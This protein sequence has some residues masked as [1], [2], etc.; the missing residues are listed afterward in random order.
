[1]SYIQTNPKKI[2]CF[3]GIFCCV[4][5]LCIFFIKEQQNTKITILHFNDLHSH[6]LP[7]NEEGTEC[8]NNENCFG[9]I[10]RMKSAIQ[11]V[12]KDNPEALLLVAGDV[13]QGTVFFTQYK[14]KFLTI[15]LNELD[16][17][18]MGLGNHEFDEGEVVFSSFIK[19]VNFP[20]LTGNMLSAT[21]SLLSPLEKTDYITTIGDKKVGIIS[22][23]TTTT[24]QISSSGEG[25][26]FEDEYS[27]LT[28][29]ATKLHNEGIDIIIAV[30]HV[31]YIKDMA[32]AREV[33]YIDVIV[34]GHSDTLLSNI[35]EK[36]EGKYTTMIQNRSGKKVAVVQTAPYGTQ[37]GKLDIIFNRDGEI[38]SAEGE[39]IILT[40]VMAEDTEL[41]QKIADKMRILSELYTN[42]IG[43]LREDVQG[44]PT[45]CRKTECAMGNLITD[46]FL[47]SYGERYNVTMSVI[48]SGS[49]R[50][51]FNEGD[52]TEAELISVLPFTDTLVVAKITGEQLFQIIETSLSHIEFRSGG[53][54]QIGGFS[55]FFNPD[56]PQNKRLCDIVDNITGTSIKKDVEYRLITTSF[57]ANGGDGYP[58]VSNSPIPNTSVRDTVSDYLKHDFYLT[59][60]SNARMYRHCK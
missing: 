40:T 42:N 4:P 11:E 13:F 32:L 7:T 41:K 12:R 15:I 2:F 33:P 29:S 8:I 24:P 37:L 31:G 45:V 3:V 46:A 23:L 1:M 57:L 39:P 30:T 22:A 27:H 35:Q 5:L 58:K 26:Y 59:T 21:T 51:S 47:K 9:G 43:N 17:D 20:V 48:N 50:A 52:I 19:N 6:L 18:V 56:K 10:A 60:N 36:A 14:E 34:G 28:R 44:D 53:F 54:L 49:I 55:I 38:L 25:V 16:I